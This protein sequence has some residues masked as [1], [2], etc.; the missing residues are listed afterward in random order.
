MTRMPMA[1]ASSL[2]A[3]RAHLQS[4]NAQSF[5]AQTPRLPLLRLQLPRIAWRQAALE[6]LCVL[7]LGAAASALVCGGIEALSLWLAR[8]RP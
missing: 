5:N 3:Q 4:F 6:L 2:H 1:Q 8:G 7:V